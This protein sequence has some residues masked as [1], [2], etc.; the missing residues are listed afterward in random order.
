MQAVVQ[1]L[2]ERC[3]PL[4]ALDMRE[5]GLLALCMGGRISSLGFPHRAKIGDAT[6]PSSHVGGWWCIP[7]PGWTQHVAA[8]CII[9]ACHFT[10][11]G[12]GAG[13]AW[14]SGRAGGCGRFLNG[15]C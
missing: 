6:A 9:T 7:E 10:E 2:Q 3:L 11:G 13:L 12:V 5:V 4:E 14:E 1:G 8:S 15:G